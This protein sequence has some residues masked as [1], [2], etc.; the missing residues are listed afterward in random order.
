[1]AR[2]RGHLCDELRH[3]MD[4]GVKKG[5]QSGISAK[6][7]TLGAMSVKLGHC[8]GLHQSISS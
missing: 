3:G 7:R 5:G 1:M 8:L 4:G 2:V 6:V